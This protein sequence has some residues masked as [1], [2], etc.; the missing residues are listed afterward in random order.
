MSNWVGIWIDHKHAFL[1]YEG[2]PVVRI[3]SKLPARIRYYG[4]PLQADGSADNQRD[5]QYLT[6]LNAY[7]DSLIERIATASALYVMGPGKAKQEF[8]NRLNRHHP[9][10]RLLKIETCDKLTPPQIAQKTQAFFSQRLT[11]HWQPVKPSVS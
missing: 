2:Q 8:K 5:R 6:H 9:D 1:A 10:A 11:P 7:Y 4:R 3:A